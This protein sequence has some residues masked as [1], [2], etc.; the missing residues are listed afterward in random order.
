MKEALLGVVN[1]EGGTA[2]RER[3]TKVQIAGKTGT[4]QV[5]RVGQKSGIDPHLVWY[6]NR[7][8]AWFAGFAPYDDPEI[9]IAVLVEHGRGVGHNAAPIAMRM[10]EEWFLRIKP[11]HAGGATQPG[12]P[13]GKPL[14]SAMKGPPK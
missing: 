12:A 9:A 14:P 4:A 5:S 11:S 8:H 10:F 13:D 7:D 2:Y 1:D 6:F 3:T